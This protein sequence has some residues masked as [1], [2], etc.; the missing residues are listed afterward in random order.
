[1]KR[2]GAGTAIVG[3]PDQVTEALQD[4]ID[5]GVSH[6]V[7]SGFPHADEARRFGRGVLPRF[8]KVTV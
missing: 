8:T 1:M 3:T 5:A 7:L 4:Y 2:K 6:L